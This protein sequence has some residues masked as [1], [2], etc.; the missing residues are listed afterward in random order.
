MKSFAV[1]ILLLSAFACKPVSTESELLEAE[2]DAQIPT[3]EGST[4]SCELAEQKITQV[5]SHINSFKRDQ[6]VDTPEHGN[7][8]DADAEVFPQMAKGEKGVKVIDNLLSNVDFTLKVKE[9]CKI[10]I[11]NNNSDT[12]TWVFTNIAKF[13][14][15]WMLMEESMTLSLQ[16]NLL[17][18]HD[19]A[20][21]GIE[22]STENEDQDPTCSDLE[23]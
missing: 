2:A 17:V 3:C 18:K 20:K 14:G 11:L 21:E 4:K 16:K 10:R 23:Q 8:Y 22:I 9:W 7:I 12:L 19:F 5:M 15:K 1:S 6:N 13:N